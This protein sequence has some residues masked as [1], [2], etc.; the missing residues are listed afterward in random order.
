MTS[1]AQLKKRRRQR[2]EPRAWIGY[3]VGYQS[4]NIYRIWIPSTGKIINTRDVIFNEHQVFDG[5]WEGFTDELL[6]TDIEQLAEWTKRNMLPDNN[7]IPDPEGEDLL[8]T[9]SLEGPDEGGI[10]EGNVEEA[11]NVRPEEDRQNGPYTDAKF[12][13]LPTPPRSPPSALLAHTIQTRSD[14]E[15]IPS[16]VESPVNSPW[17]AAFMAGTKAAPMAKSDGNILDKA[18]IERRLRQGVKMP[19]RQLPEPPK[20]HK[21]LI[22][23]QFGSLFK[24]AEVDHLQS[25]AE[26]RSWTEIRKKD[27]RAAGKQILDCMWVYIYKFNKH[28]IFEKCK[29]R[30]V[31]R[32]DQQARGQTQ[33]TYAATLAGR[34]FRTLIAIAAKF[35]LELIQYDVVNAFVHAPID[36]DIFMRM[37]RGYEKKGTILMLNKALYGLRISPLLWQKEFTRTLAEL[38]YQQAPHEPCCYKKNGILIF[39]YVDDIVVAY[40]KNRQRQVDELAQQLQEKYKISGG[41]P[42]QWFLGME[43]HRDRPN[44]R[45]WLAQTAYIE[46]IAKMA[47]KRNLSH[48]VPMTTEELKPRTDAAKPAEVNS[49]QR[50]IGSILF[51]AIS[52]RPDIAFATSRL[53]RFLTNPSQKHHD[54]ADRVLLY[55]ENTKHLALCFTDTD[56]FTAASDSSFADNTVDRKSSQ[57]F[58]MKLFG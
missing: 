48:K 57:A 22:N 7:E 26:M 49:Y 43:I 44:R 18:Q 14:E 28:G 19:R 39:F 38:G 52:T 55:L 27:P 50:K 56:E 24:Q 15:E 5:N 31:V 2:L 54:A 29:A 16:A 10:Q 36:Q 51:A 37:P 3:L 23:H 35:N 58:A 13:L 46:K 9:E 41:D 33:E 32:G 4:S 47:N 1:D 17:Q 25:H 20:W 21:D 8:E 12:T 53:A 40:R 11:E 45:I 42:I 34:S 6:T 30:L